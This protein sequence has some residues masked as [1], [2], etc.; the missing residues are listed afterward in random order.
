MV[1]F[2]IDY[3]ELV[4]ALRRQSYFSTPEINPVY[5]AVIRILHAKPS[6]PYRWEN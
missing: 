5:F 4:Q 1:N 3:V 2:A 6:M